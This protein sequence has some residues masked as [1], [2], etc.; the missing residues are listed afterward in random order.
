MKIL[1]SILKTDLGDTSLKKKKHIKPSLEH[2]Y[3]T[4]Y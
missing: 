1:T 3:Y 4:R 2:H